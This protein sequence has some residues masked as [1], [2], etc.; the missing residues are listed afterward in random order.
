MQAGAQAKGERNVLP[1]KYLTTKIDTQSW[2]GGGGEEEKG[3]REERVMGDW[4]RLRQKDYLL[5]RIRPILD[6]PNG[7][8]PVY[9]VTLSF[10]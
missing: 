3:E 7:R 8:S 10:F 9:F 6:E 2:I 4:L 5:S 1:E